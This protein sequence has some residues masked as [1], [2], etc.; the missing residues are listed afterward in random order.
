MKDG[1]DSSFAV[2]RW[3]KNKVGNVVDDVE[4]HSVDDGVLEGWDLIS[5][6]LVKFDVK[7]RDLKDMVPRVVK[8]L[9]KDAR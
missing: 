5:E 3:L 6:V 7:P 8:L 4:I 2:N 9:R 1:C